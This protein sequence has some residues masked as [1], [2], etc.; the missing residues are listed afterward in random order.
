MKIIIAGSSGTGKTTMANRL[1]ERWRKM[2]YEEGELAM[3]EADGFIVLYDVGD[4][5]TFMDVP[6]HIRR[7]T[8]H[9]KRPNVPIVVCGN[10][11]DYYGNRKLDQVHIQDVDPRYLGGNIVAVKNT[12]ASDYVCVNGGDPLHQPMWELFRALNYEVSDSSSDSDYNSDSE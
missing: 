8:Q 2:I 6:E 5:D 11:Y 1:R 10:K 9:A 7:I 4:W 12:S 3:G